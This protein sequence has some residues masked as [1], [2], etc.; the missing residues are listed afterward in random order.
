MEKT[1]ILGTLLGIKKNT[2]RKL[3][4][5]FFFQSETPHREFGQVGVFGL[6]RMHAFA[7]QNQNLF[8]KVR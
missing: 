6:E 7:N 2:T 5:S 8:A 1:R 3:L 4:T